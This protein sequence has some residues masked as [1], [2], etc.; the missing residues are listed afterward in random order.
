VTKVAATELL[1]LAQRYVELSTQLDTVRDQIRRCVANGVDPDPPPIVRPTRAGHRPGKAGKA[2]KTA[3]KVKH[4]KPKAKPKPEPAKPS[5][6]QIW[7]KAKADD[8]QALAF[9]RAQPGAKAIEIAK[10]T[11]MRSTSLANRL[12]RLA[13]KGLIARAGGGRNDGWQATATAGI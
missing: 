9:I 5:R 12:K 11:G 10:A 8:Q 13:S 1:A 3:A 2:T 4:A 6:D 7:A